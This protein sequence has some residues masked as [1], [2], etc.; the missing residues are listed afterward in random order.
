M[1]DAQLVA[2]A[3]QGD[4]AAFETLVRNYQ[5]IMVAS[6]CQLI[7]SQEDAEDV[8]QEAFLEAF[9]DLEQVARPR[10]IPCLALHYPAA[11]LLSLSPATTQ[12][13]CAVG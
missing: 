3:L 2:A 6:A 11:K 5:R 4:I 12:G 7:R 8:A 9:R 1:D 10:Q 13:R